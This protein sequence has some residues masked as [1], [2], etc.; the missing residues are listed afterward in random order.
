MNCEQASERFGIY[1]DLPGSS[2]ERIAVD[3]HIAECSECREQFRLWEES[4]EM[5]KRLPMADA[6]LESEQTVSQI[7]RRVMDRIYAEQ[8]WFMPA[9]RK[10]Y[11]FSVRFRIKIALFLTALLAVFSCSFLYTVWK[12]NSASNQWGS[13]AFTAADGVGAQT[14]EVPVASLSDPIVLK[15][16]PQM[17]EYWVAL[18]LLGVIVV[19][20]MLNWFS[21]IRS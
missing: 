4:S 2:P 17:P 7:S 11:A 3:E 9:V 13:S 6:E 10:T 21:R 1:H 15:M 19:L 5:I 8:S 16:A 14:V 12:R 18:S 20:L